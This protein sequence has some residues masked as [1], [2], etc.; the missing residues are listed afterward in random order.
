MGSPELAWEL[1][2]TAPDEL[3]RPSGLDRLSWIPA[4]VPGT[5]AAALQA[6]DIATP[7]QGVALDDHDWWFRTTFAARE[8]DELQLGGLATIADVYIDGELMLHSESMYARHRVPL[9]AGARELAI[10][11]R[12]LRPRLARAARRAPA[13]GRRWWPTATSASSARC[14]SAARRPSRPAPR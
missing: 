9:P 4:R 7:E 13:G 12:A 8:G 14:C 2:S 5:V 3:A 10:C 6:A 11:C 1:A